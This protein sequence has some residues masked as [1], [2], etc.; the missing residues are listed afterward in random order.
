M[1]HGITNNRIV[2]VLEMNSFCSS[3]TWYVMSCYSVFCVSVFTLILMQVH[4]SVVPRPLA[5]LWC[6]QTLS[7][8]IIWEWPRDKQESLL[9]KH[10]LKERLHHENKDIMFLVQ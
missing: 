6:F 9:K 10:F 8:K 2:D 1:K 7:K 3:L 4:S 5:G